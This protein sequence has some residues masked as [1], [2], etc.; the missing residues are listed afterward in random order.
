MS[1]NY[2]DAQGRAT[3]SGRS[4]EDTTPVQV[5]GPLSSR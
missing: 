2:A 5:I 4:T 3:R 1:D